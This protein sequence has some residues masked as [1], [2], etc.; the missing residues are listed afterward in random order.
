MAEVIKENDTEERAGPVTVTSGYVIRI[1]TRL[2][3]SHFC[4]RW[5]TSTSNLTEHTHSLPV[6]PRG[7]FTLPVTALICPLSPPELH[8]GFVEIWQSNARITTDIKCFS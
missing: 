7:F 8:K 3:E 6:M 1:N 2:F 5:R 4:R